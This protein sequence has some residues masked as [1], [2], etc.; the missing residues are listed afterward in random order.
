MN[1]NRAAQYHT[2]RERLEK[3]DGVSAT[4]GSSPTSTNGRGYTVASTLEKKVPVVEC[5]MEQRRVVPTVFEL[6]GHALL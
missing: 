3:C 5:F 6:E 2:K 1:C 4:P